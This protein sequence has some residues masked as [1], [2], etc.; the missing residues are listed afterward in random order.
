MLEFLSLSQALLEFN[1][2]RLNE[3]FVFR[4]TLNKCRNT[5]T[6]EKIASVLD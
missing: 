1:L 5:S 4:E 3:G 2:S 6:K